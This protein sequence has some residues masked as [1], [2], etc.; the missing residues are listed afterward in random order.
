MKESSVAFTGHRSIPQERLTPLREALEKQI[1]ALY[2]QG[3]QTFY[4]GAACGFDLHAAAMTCRVRL[5]HP[6]IRLILALPGQG[7]TEKWSDADKKLYETIVREADE[8]VYPC[9]EERYVSRETYLA[10]DRYM[11]DQSTVCLCYL[12][13][14][15]G[16]TAYTVRYAEEQKKVVIN[17]ADLLDPG[18]S[19]R[20]DA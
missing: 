18:Q 9:G 6:E 16:G 8:V 7:Q 13:K 10:R 19:D 11:I 1:E 14:K 12:T 17:I 5:R 20:E 3:Y 15:T 4:N 2:Y